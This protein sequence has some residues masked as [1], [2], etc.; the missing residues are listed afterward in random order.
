MKFLSSSLAIFVACVGGTIAMTSVAYAFDNVPCAKSYVHH[1][2]KYGDIYVQDC[3]L[4]QN[5]VPV[6]QEPSA[7][8]RPVGKLNSANGNWF[9]C[10]RQAGTQCPWQRVQ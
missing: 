4:T 8:A 2:D 9:L 7:S 3:R 1:T 10:Q 5:N 6:L